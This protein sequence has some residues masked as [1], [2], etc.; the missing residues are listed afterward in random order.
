MKNT[1]N[2]QLK[3]PVLFLISVVAVIKSKYRSKVVKKQ[4]LVAISKMLPRFEALY[5][6]NKHASPADRLSTTFV[7]SF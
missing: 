7:L 3:I 5:I 6:A 1:E 4:M 2:N